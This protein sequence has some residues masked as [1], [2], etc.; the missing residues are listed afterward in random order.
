MKPSTILFCATTAQAAVVWWPQQ[1]PHHPPGEPCPHHRQEGQVSE[2]VTQTGPFSLR[3]PFFRHIRITWPLSHRPIL[4]SPAEIAD[5]VFDDI[6]RPPQAEPIQ[7]QEEE[8]EVTILPYTGHLDPED[9]PPKAEEFKP[10][11]EEDEEEDE[12]EE[13]EEVHED[14]RRRAK[15]ANKHR[16]LG[17]REFLP[18]PAI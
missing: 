11:E 15:P 5:Q 12:D 17:R 7:Q 13:E 14:L 18:G 6:D 8:K 3:F 4:P 2:H 1:Q 16:R 10:E 9:F